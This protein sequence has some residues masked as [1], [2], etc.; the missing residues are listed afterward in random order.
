MRK[1]LLFSIIVLVGITFIARLFYLQVYTGKA[2]NIYEDNAIR[3]VFYYPKRGYVYDRNRELLVASLSPPHRTA[4][5]IRSRTSSSPTSIG[6]ATT[7]STATILKRNSVEQIII[8]HDYHH[9]SYLNYQKK[10][11]LFF[12][13]KC[14]NIKGF[15]FKS[16]P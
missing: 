11:M 10:I 14:G 2:Y 7:G 9:L 4:S 5:S 15:I 12:K 1:L 3:K 8:L 16:V 6:S 13:K